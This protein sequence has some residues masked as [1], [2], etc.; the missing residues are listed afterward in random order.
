MWNFILTDLVNSMNYLYDGVSVGLLYVTA[1]YVYRTIRRTKQPKLRVSLFVFLIYVVVVLKIALFSREAGSRDSFDLDILG[2]W[3][4]DARAKSYVIENVLLFFPLGVLLPM[5][6]ERYHRFLSC[7]S[8]GVFSSV[9]I[10]I[11][12]YFTKRGY[13][14]LD[15][16]IMNSLGT[17]LGFCAY[18]LLFACVFRSR[19]LS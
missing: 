1:I 19:R 9:T 12:Q 13:C 4:S 14:Q 18:Y 5:I 17:A 16:V 11:I 3:G 7:F 10:E 2:T 6:C 8:M 15:D